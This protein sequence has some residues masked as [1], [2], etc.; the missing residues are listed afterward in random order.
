VRNKENVTGVG[1]NPAVI[2]ARD[3]HGDDLNCTLL[4]EYK[5]ALPA[6]NINT[7]FLGL[8]AYS[9]EVGFACFARKSVFSLRS[10]LL[11]ACCRSSLR[12]W[13]IVNSCCKLF[14]V[15]I[16]CVCYMK[17]CSFSQIKCRMT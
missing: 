10:L 7:V 2:Y 4:Q 9:R 1:C 16:K 17:I 13:K 12:Y 15:M 3:Q 5:S 11:K 8:E 14:L 6:C